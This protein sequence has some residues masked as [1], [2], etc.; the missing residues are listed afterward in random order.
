MQKFLKIEPL[1]GATIFLKAIQVRMGILAFLVVTGNLLIAQAP[2]GMNFQAIA[3]DLQG[4]PAK[5]R[6]INVKG[7]IFQG[8]AVGGKSVWEE[9]FAVFQLPGGCLLIIIRIWALLN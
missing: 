6:T 7:T 8:S 1:K 9:T 3:K 2:Q 4:N 5:T